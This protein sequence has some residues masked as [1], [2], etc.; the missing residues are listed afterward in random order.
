MTVAA[1]TAVGTPAQA[2]PRPSGTG[3]D[4]GGL[5]WTTQAVAPGVVVRTGVLSRATAPYW[6]VTIDAPA[7]NDLTGQPAV[8]ELGTAQWAQGTV[9]Q[10]AAAG[11]PARQDVIDWPDYTD[12]PHGV[13]GVRVR[14]GSYPAQADAQAAATRLRSA[15]FPTATAEWTGYDVD[16]PV[17]GEQVHVAIIDPRLFHGTVEAT[18]DGTV[19]QR[20]K[21]STVAAKLGSLVGVN[22]GFFVTSDADGY[23]GVPSSLAAYQGRLE[24]ESVG[25]RTA[26]LLDHG[27]ARIEPLTSTVTVRVGAAGHA[28]EGVN[29]KPGL[30]RDCGRP[31]ARPTTRPRQD[32]TC[33]STDEMVLFT[34]EFGSAA[35]P[36]GP[37]AQVTLDPTGVVV[38]AGGRGGQM[39]AGDSVL[40]AIGG[41]ADWLAAHAPV[42]THLL[43]AKQIRDA[44]G[45][46]VVLSPGGSIAS[47]AP[48]LLAGGQPAI[49]AATEGV[50]DPAD[51][52]FG[53]AWAEQRQPRTIAGI[54]ARGRL[55]LVTV[56]GRE[57]GISE[58]VTLT[59]EA[60]LMRMLGA[61]R[62]MNLDGGGSTAMAVHGVL[63]NHTSDST[64]E[65]ADGDTVQVLPQG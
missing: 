57:P 24:S 7:T 1:G 6:T 47:A 59:E 11:Y 3:W 20:E 43:V 53:Y 39:P 50:V 29:R 8:A 49:D 21:T 15:G 44:R 51:L 28:V 64:G 2:S 61:V 35:L 14:T 42:G 25:D 37:G 32:V 56:D 54:D 17:D 26:L 23:Q 9:D 13:E 63:V 38:A 41:S 36:T 34:P 60:Q 5:R 52:S 16:Q 30:I 19:A 65:R 46:P 31:D 62:A 12:T 33:T 45:A 27:F 55:L 4:G 22:G 58:G 40:Q 48:M 18:H 10:L